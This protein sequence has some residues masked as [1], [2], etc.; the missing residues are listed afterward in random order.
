MGL[1]TTNKRV[2]IAGKKIKPCPFCGKD[3]GVD[4]YDET[5]ER[6]RVIRCMNC[7]AVG[8]WCGQLSDA[9]E[10]WDERHEVKND[11]LRLKEAGE[12]GALAA[13]NLREAIMKR[14]KKEDKA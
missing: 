11:I 10:A 14:A 5:M 12:R 8:P 2:V 13:K 9:I 4:S 3:E 6:N 1:E 7:G